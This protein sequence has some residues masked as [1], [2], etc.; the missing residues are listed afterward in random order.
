MS[1]SRLNQLL[2]PPG[3][4]TRVDVYA[5]LDG[6]RDDRVYSMTQASYLEQ[7][8]LY[9]G[10]LPHELIVTAPWLVRLQPEHRWSERIL[11]HA[12]S[13]SWGMFLRTE[14]NMRELRKHLRRFLRVKDE[15]GRVLI[16]R[17]YDPRVLRV[18]LPTC[19][20]SELRTFFGP[21]QQML[22]EDADPA[23]A[24]EFSL[25]GNELKQ[26]SRALSG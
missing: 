24:I 9:A 14:T 5:V 21:I 13:N 1:V 11:T 3:I 26:T 23:N 18:Y 17:Y 2:W 10:D 19:T 15:S 6:A 20:A 4:S 22:V 25:A 12:W 8:C 16:F 7:E